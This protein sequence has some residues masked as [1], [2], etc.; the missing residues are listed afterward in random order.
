MTAMQGY[1]APRRRPGE[2]GV[3]S[4]DH[5]A[6]TVP[7]LKVAHHF[8][9]NFGLRVPEEGGKLGMYAEG[10]PHRW[11]VIGEGPKKKLSYISFGVFEEDLARFRQRLQEQRICELDPPEGHSS[12][13]IWLRDAGA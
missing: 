7:D 1:I 9:S 12:N 13:G 6:L 3:H 4:L 10:V 2:L 11:G 5:F 8:Y